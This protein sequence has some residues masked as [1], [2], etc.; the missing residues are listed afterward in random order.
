MRD[1]RENPEH[2]RA[3]SSSVILSTKPVGNSVGT[4]PKE[5]TPIH[6]DL[7]LKAV[8]YKQN[9]TLPPEQGRTAPK[10]ARFERC[11]NLSLDCR[12]VF[13]FPFRSELASTIPTVV[14]GKNLAAGVY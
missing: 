1:A 13:K 14:V 5:T 7:S 3:F 2:Y 12:Q 8:K 11:L 9:R 10:P 6:K 4:A